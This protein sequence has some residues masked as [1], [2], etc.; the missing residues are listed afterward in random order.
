MTLR[1]N[2][3][4]SAVRIGVC[5]TTMFATVA[6]IA[7]YS[8]MN[9]SPA[10]VLRMP[11]VKAQSGCSASTMRGAYG[12]GASGTV[13]MDGRTF[14]NAEI[15]RMDFDGAG[16]FTGAISLVVAGQR[17]EVTN[18]SGSYSVADDCTGNGSATVNG[19]PY[20]FDFVVANG[21]ATILTLET[22]P[23]W[24]MSGVA[25]RMGQ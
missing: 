20:K 1:W 25:Y 15:A 8:A 9:Q 23:N 21:G 5:L 3:K 18:L 7:Y 11:V 14:E 12:Y 10:S 19:V 16:S 22:N 17:G 24:T 6:G 13:T 2:W 4:Q